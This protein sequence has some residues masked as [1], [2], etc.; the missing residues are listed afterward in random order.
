MEGVQRLGDPSRDLILP[1]EHPELFLEA[2]AL[3]GARIR[4]V[5]LGNEV[6]EGEAA[7]GPRFGIALQRLELRLE[8]A[9]AAKER[10]ELAALVGELREVVDDFELGAGVEEG[11]LALLAV[12]LDQLLPGGAQE[13]RRDLATVE[14]GAVAPLAAAAGWLRPAQPWPSP[15]ASPGSSSRAAALRS[16]TA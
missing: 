2:I 8:S 12:N 6:L 3:A 16:N 7:L 5:N 15:T 11:E 1:F 4:G 10:P 14:A 13:A 9:G